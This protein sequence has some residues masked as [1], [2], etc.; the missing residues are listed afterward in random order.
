[1]SKQIVIDKDT[2]FEK[3]IQVPYI[4]I[5]DIETIQI[6]VASELDIP[7]K[8]LMLEDNNT[9]T[10]EKE[11]KLSVP[12]N[13]T[14]KKIA[15]TDID[16]MKISFLTLESVIF[17]NK[18]KSFQTIIEKVREFI[19]KTSGE[20]DEK[21][22][23]CAVFYYLFSK[24]E[25]ANLFDEP[26]SNLYR[27]N[28]DLVFSFI[29]YIE[30]SPYF[31]TL[32][33]FQRHYEQFVTKIKK[34]MKETDD[35]NKDINELNSLLRENRKPARE[36]KL[37]ISRERIKFVNS[38][39]V[40]SPFHKDEMELFENL[41]LSRDMPFAS[42]AGFSKVLKS[43]VPPEEFTKQ[44]DKR[45]SMF[46]LNRKNETVS[47]MYSLN[48]Y[49]IIYI[50]RVNNQL[51][52]S[53][54][55]KVEGIS[56][57][58][59]VREE[60]IIERIINALNIQDQVP[61]IN[62]E[63][64]PQYYKGDFYIPNLSISRIVM[65][66]IIMNDE[67]ISKMFVVNE[68][69]TT[70]NK[71]GGISIVYLPSEN[72][73]KNFI[74]SF[75][76]TNGVVSSANK[77]FIKG[78]PL[79]L[80]DT[81]LGISFKTK[82]N[83]TL[84]IL[85]ECISQMIA[86][87][88]KNEK[89][90]FDEYKATDCDFSSESKL[91]D[92]IE[93][94]EMKKSGKKALKLRDYLPDVFVTNYPAVC[95]KQPYIVEDEDDAEERIE[96]GEDIMKY[97]LYNE[98]EQYYYSCNNHKDEGFIYP[99]LKKTRLSEYLLPC[100]FTT[101]QSDKSLRG[102]YEKGIEEEEEKEKKKEADFK[103]YKTSKIMPVGGV[104]FLS[105]NVEK[106]FSIIDP[107]NT[108]LRSGVSVGINSCLEAIIRASQTEEQINKLSKK[109]RE[110]YLEG[111][112]KRII[113][114]ITKGSSSQNSYQYSVQS[115]INFINSEN[116][117]DIRLLQDALEDLFQVHLL[118]FQVNK[119]NLDGEIIS[120][121]YINNL[122]ALTQK[123]KYRY[124]I[125]LY[126]TM[127]SRIDNLF[128]PHYEFVCRY[129][130]NDKKISSVFP[131]DDIISKSLEDI[132]DNIF[133]RYS[134]QL[135][136]KLVENPF[137]TPIRSQRADSSGKIRV[138]SFTDGTSLFIQPMDSLPSS[139]VQDD[140]VAE[141]VPV[142]YEKAISFLKKENVKD[143][144]FSIVQDNVVGVHASKNNLR[145]YIPII[146]INN[147][148]FINT[149]SNV[150]APSFILKEDIITNFAKR[151]KAA[152]NLIAVCV[153]LFSLYISS[154]KKSIDDDS[155]LQTVLDFKNEKISIDPSLTEE[156][157][158]SIQRKF[159]NN[160]F[161]KEDKII[162]R[163]KEIQKK[164]VY[165]LFVKTRQ[166]SEY[167]RNYSTME[168]IPDYYQ[169]ERDFKKDD[170]SLLFISIEAIN[171]WRNAMTRI[172]ESK[173]F[174]SIDESFIN[175][176]SVHN[177]TLFSN[178]KITDDKDLYLC[179]KASTIDSAVGF[180]D[181]LRNTKR[182]D[183]QVAKSSSLRNKQLLKKYK[184]KM[185]FVNNADGSDIVL[186]TYGNESNY[187]MVFKIENEINIICLFKYKQD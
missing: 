85:K 35:R 123:R 70:I 101:P 177:I 146:T 134:N 22:I 73:N 128:Y 126:E 54:D 76:I 23:L 95:G 156:E 149:I 144:T 46:V 30:S 155:L 114:V 42:V 32:F 6:R 105:P 135:N 131:T 111:Y 50:S 176:T 20:T 150:P 53:I 21:F 94:I 79:R 137:V 162:V 99:G 93:K 104:G 169:D 29:S 107:A 28:I 145:F 60:V 36:V 127:G 180:F 90:V 2:D 179:V 110:K 172:K 115:L 91:I 44:L 72:E 182:V 24:P 8:F 45:F 174:T 117:L 108:Y 185:V 81:F 82:N 102:M 181:I 184:G 39:I 12:F 3:T 157:Y 113:E 25:N 178:E 59:E 4:N 40:L 37:S 133:I 34:E 11:V 31:G 80:G 173:V 118:V 143:Y 5:D 175:N 13:K 83:Y 78:T 26:S 148:E 138:L 163:S 68:Q 121:Y 33:S 63:I 48:S 7:L 19:F 86:I 186:K 64:V 120:P 187:I 15:L 55:S 170:S 58:V 57:N 165:S 142:N 87:Y 151:E 147:I 62:C 136:T 164:I 154:K 100:C 17:L 18:K 92:N 171:R 96:N 167:I 77:R 116:F 112:R 109:D 61:E 69:F 74:T 160:K 1:M 125:I 10:E 51:E 47:N 27:E 98:F 41:R 75:S 129:R 119:D 166:N 124:T 14:T 158:I 159:I 168:F 140:A 106:L 43:F 84:A 66:D 49:S 141:L 38:K 71:K 52:I 132:Y 67:F 88:K 152:R 139:M 97:P 122:Y 183:I 16:K 130:P 65:Q 153:Y 56:Q 89:E 9:T 103:I 161:V